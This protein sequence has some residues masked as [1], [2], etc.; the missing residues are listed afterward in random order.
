MPREARW[1]ALMMSRPCVSFE[2]QAVAPNE[3]SWF[4]S[5]AVGRLASTTMRV[6]R[7]LWCSW[8]THAALGREPKL[9]STT[10]GLRLSSTASSSSSSIEVSTSSRLGSSEIS[11]CRP[12]ATRSSKRADTIVIGAR[13]FTGSKPPG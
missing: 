11:S 8:Y 3:R 13:V 5:A 6:S 4:D 12:I 7:L 2:M 1:I 9:S 10:F